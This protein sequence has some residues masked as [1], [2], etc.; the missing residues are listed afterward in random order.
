MYDQKAFAATHPR[1]LRTVAS[2]FGLEAAP[3]GSCRVLELGCAAGANLIPMAFEHPASEFVGVDLSA[4][5]IETGQV[6]ISELDIKNIKLEHRDIMNVQ[7]KDGKFDYIICH[8][9]FS[10]VPAKVR[11][12]ILW[13]CRRLL[14][15]KGV[16]YVSF[17]TY[18]GWHLREGIRQMMIYH[19]AQFETV[20]EKIGQARALLKF[21]SD[22]VPAQN[23]AYGQLLQ[24]EVKSLTKSSDTYLFHDFLEPINEPMYFYEF[25]EQAGR[26]GLQYLGNAD[27][28][29]MLTIGLPKEA[30]Q[31]LKKIGTD[32]CRM[33]QYMDFLRNRQFR[34]T[35]VCHKERR[36]TR[37]I[38]GDQLK[39]M[40][41]SSKIRR[42]SERDGP[43][44]EKAIEFKAP[45]GT[46]L[47]VQSATARSALTT[48]GDR[49]PAF[50]SFDE[51]AA[52][53]SPLG[54]TSA[55]RAQ[56]VDF[57]TQELIRWIAVA[58]VEMSV[59]AVGLVVTAGERPL[60][61][62]LARVQ[63]QKQEFATNL[64]HQTVFVQEALRHAIAL[65]D[66]RRDRGQIIEGLEALLQDGK[67]QMRVGDEKSV[68]AESRKANLVTMLEEF[69]QESARTLRNKAC[70][71]W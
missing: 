43:A 49:W 3:S 6:L 19:S 13:L 10:W 5:Q 57:L 42:V 26:Q 11:R 38:N 12:R 46:Q 48:L 27:F 56:R 16:A 44:G 64:R 66:G 60:A 36:L 30:Q 18:P 25:V 20:R 8:G 29:T 37:N 68:D 9:V 61:S 71:F 7:A 21:L 47:Q 58:D 70:R 45:N 62:K 65:F 24:R 14:T 40:W 67:I 32:V 53:A 15:E 28:H 17:N 50:V 55:Q 34:H 54:E 63:L 4:K 39:S 33:E 51:L 22:S 1:R 69:L 41:Y 31:T 35:L 59:E 2:L 23:N 52:S